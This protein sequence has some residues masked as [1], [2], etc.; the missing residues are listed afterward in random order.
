MC[1]F[2]RRETVFF[3]FPCLPSRGAGVLGSFCW[4]RT[5]KK[6]VKSQNRGLKK[7][8]GKI[9]GGKGQAKKE[10]FGAGLVSWIMFWIP[11]IAS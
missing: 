4:K 1:D 7:S 6:Y 10:T 2:V 9:R 3:P 5:P 11:K 8:L